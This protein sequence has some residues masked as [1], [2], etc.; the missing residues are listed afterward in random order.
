MPHTDKGGPVP[1]LDQMHI[2]GVDHRLITPRQ[3][4]VSE[5]ALNP[6]RALSFGHVSTYSFL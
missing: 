2:L 5:V 3:R 4:D 6:D 1:A